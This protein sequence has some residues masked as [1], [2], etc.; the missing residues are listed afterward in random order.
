[1]MG[2]WKDIYEQLCERSDIMQI[3]L[4]IFASIL[5]DAF[6]HGEHYKSRVTPEEDDP[7]HATTQVCLMATSCTLWNKLTG[8]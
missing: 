7:Q 2:Q 8:Q 5:A 6:K 4:Q 1:M 3:V